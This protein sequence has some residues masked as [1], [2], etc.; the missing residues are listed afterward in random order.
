MS[1][2]LAC[3]CYLSHPLMCFSPM[4]VSFMCWT[5]GVA[6]CACHSGWYFNR[7]FKVQLC[8]QQ[9]EHACLSRPQK[10][11]TAPSKP[12]TGLA[13]QKQCQQVIA[14]GTCSVPG[15]NHQLSSKPST[16]I[17]HM[18]ASGGRHVRQ[19]THVKDGARKHAAPGS[20]LGEATCHH[21]A[22]HTSLP[23]RVERQHNGAPQAAHL[24]EPQTMATTDHNMASRPPVTYSCSSLS[25]TAP[26]AQ[27]QASRSRARCRMA[28]APRPGAAARRQTRAARPQAAPAQRRLP[29]APNEGR[30]A[31]AQAPLPPRPPPQPERRSAPAPAR[32]QLQPGHALPQRARRQDLLAAPQQPER[33]ARP[34]RGQRSAA[35]APVRRR[36][37]APPPGPLPRAPARQL[38]RAPQAPH[39]PRPRTARGWRRAAGCCARAPPGRCAR[40]SRAR[41][42]PP[43]AAACSP[44]PTPAACPRP[45]A[46]ALTLVPTLAP[47]W[48]LRP[49]A[50]RPPW[51]PQPPRRCTGRPQAPRPGKPWGSSLT[52]PAQ[53]VAWVGRPPGAQRPCCQWQCAA[54]RSDTRSCRNG[55]AGM[56]KQACAMA[57]NARHAPVHTAEAPQPARC[58]MLLPSAAQKGREQS[59]PRGRGH[60]NQDMQRTPPDCTG[61]A[62]GGLE[63]WMARRAPGTRH[64][65]GRAAAATRTAWSS[66]TLTAARSAPAAP[67]QSARAS[68]ARTVRRTYISNQP[69]TGSAAH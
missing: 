11:V 25:V 20:F 45:R 57:P 50:S 4:C 14:A 32:A 43:A 33:A 69:N 55:A 29:R 27:R 66:A 2:V 56:C 47:R 38:P 53:V 31:P 39:R 16:G 65:P 49:G 35:A 24:L 15:D 42:A 34:P 7:V 26:R 21:G 48:T 19:R 41:A 23:L 60:A 40:G 3:E 1:V 59:I 67:R 13:T 63:G 18:V 30:P 6:T 5:D 8:R 61:R 51:A 9:H 62:C 17:A 54:G 64:P 37:L 46:R 10:A 36:A 52:A 44:A 12:H 58:A 22:F 28:R 68:P